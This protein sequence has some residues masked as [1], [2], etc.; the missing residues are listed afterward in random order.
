MLGRYSHTCD[1]TRW[2]DF[3][4]RGIHVHEAETSVEPCKVLHEGET[5]KFL[6]RLHDGLETESVIMRIDGLKRCRHT[7]CISSQIGCALGCVFC[8]TGRMGLLRNLS[9]AEIIAQWHAARH[10]LDTVIDNI[11]FMGMGEPLDNLD[12]V[13]PALDILT[14]RYGPS[15]AS[16]RICISTV[17]RISGINRL[18]Q[19]TRKNG[20]KRLSLAV[21]INAPND[22]IRKKIMPLAKDVS[23]DTLREALMDYPRHNKGGMMAEY[24]LIPN[25][26]DTKENAIELCAYLQ[27]IGCGLNV[28]P[29]NPIEGCPWSRPTESSIETFI[30]TARSTGQFVHRRKTLGVELMAAC[31]QLGVQQK[32]RGQ[33]VSIDRG[34]TFS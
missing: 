26:N 24:V 28:I 21:S 9:I 29:Y 15:I 18:A 8:Q 14:D 20:Y 23:M 5:T 33:F 2:K 32:T 11:V 27:P 19:L 13:I 16:S 1:I 10:A 34:V 3:F 7:L 6:L 25:V 4:R 12:A 31:G 17:G 22:L 30:E